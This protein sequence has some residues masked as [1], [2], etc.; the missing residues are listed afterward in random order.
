MRNGVKKIISKDGLYW[1]LYFL[2][3]KSFLNNIVSDKTYIRLLYRVSMGKSLNIDNP[4]TYNEKLQWLKLYDRNPLYT[5]LVDKQSVKEWVTEKI[6]PEYVIK[7]LKIYDN[8]DEID[9]NELPNQFV[10]KTTHYGDSLGVV[11]C[12]DKS[13][14]D[15]ENAKRRLE[16]SMKH[17]YYKAGREW[18]YKNVERKI[19][20]EQYKEDQF[21]E[22][23]DYKFFCFD[24]VVKAMFIA[25]NRSTGG[26][27]FDY[28]DN[29]FNHLDF[30]QSHPMYGK[31]I[32]KP[33]NFEKMQQLAAT[34]SK[35]LP[36]VR[37]DLYNVNGD[38]FFGE[39]T[40]FHYGGMVPF[41][42]EEWDYRFGE[43]LTLP[44]KT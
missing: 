40:F 24:G 28:F 13:N 5:T 9:L 4:I 26:V 31:P 43:W 41:H 34:L 17:D 1:L 25:T 42:P 15:F 18:P 16:K 14:F 21:G 22:L 38:I 7:T 36:H 39:M 37:V 11:V 3:T 6:G 8:I 33:Q 27:C 2:I 23:R 30:T 35:G 29:K 44:N 20:A 12:K 19:I 10:L 32:E